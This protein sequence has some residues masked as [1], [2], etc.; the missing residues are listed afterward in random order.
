MGVTL[1]NHL[2]RYD[3]GVTRE[4]VKID[5]VDTSKPKLPDH[6]VIVPPVD[7]RH[8]DLFVPS[9]DSEEG[10]VVRPSLDRVAGAKT[11]DEAWIKH[12]GDHLSQEEL[13]NGQVVTWSGFHSQMQEISCVK[14]LAEIGILPLFPDKS[15]DSG[16]IKHF[17]LIVNKSIAFLNPGHTPVIGADQPL[18]AIAKQLQWQF[19]TILGEHMYVVM[20]GG[21]HI[22]DKGQLMLGKF[23]RGS[24]WEWAM[25][26]AE[27]FTAGES[28]FSTR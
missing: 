3:M 9:S 17:M 25:T 15:T 13:D 23:I 28:C 4:P 11:R 20:M 24:G 14:P 26:T 19:P 2:S 10:A 27:V 1:T 22:E 6:Y 18:Y 5:R 7:L 21:L 8:Q 16:I 12:V